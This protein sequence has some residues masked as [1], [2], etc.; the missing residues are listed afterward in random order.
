[1]ESKSKGAFYQTYA[2]SHSHT[3]CMFTSMGDISTSFS[4]LVFSLSLHFAAAAAAAATVDLLSGFL[5]FHF[6]R[7]K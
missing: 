4:P 1:M 2:L 5:S 7:V 3:L 6:C